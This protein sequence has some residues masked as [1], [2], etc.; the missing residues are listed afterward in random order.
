MT[1][2]QVGLDEHEAALCSLE[3]AFEAHA[4]DLSGVKVEPRF[5]PLVTAPRFAALLRRMNL[6]W[7]D[8]VISV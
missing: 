4:I 6:D 5:A 2:V 8:T 7:S 1:L 3:Q